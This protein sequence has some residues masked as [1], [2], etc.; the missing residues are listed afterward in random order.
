MRLIFPGISPTVDLPGEPPAK[1]TPATRSVTMLLQS[2]REAPPDS[3]AWVRVPAGLGKGS[4]VTLEIE[5]ASADKAPQAPAQPQTAQKTYWGCGETPAEGQP[6]LSPPKPES[7]RTGDVSFASWPTARRDTLPDSAKAAGVYTLETSYAGATAVTLGEEQEFLP[8][9]QLAVEASSLNFSKAMEVKWKPVAG[10]AG[11]LVTAFGGNEKETIHWT[12]SS[13]PDK[14]AGLEDRALTED[15]LKSLLEEKIILAPETTSC[16]I[17]EGIFSG[18]KGGVI[19][20]IAFG[21]DKVQERNSI[22]TQVL[23]RSQLTIPVM[24]AGSD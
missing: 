2:R 24:A 4:R 17:P 9:V 20:I 1:V 18:A 11:Y 8:P 16:T 12:S 15:A 22:Q 3:Y 6:R 7:A 21:R 13:D 5:R 23:V 19:T 10:A 14:S